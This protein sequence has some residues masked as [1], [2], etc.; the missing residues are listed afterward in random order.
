M[1]G[2]GDGAAVGVLREGVG[3]ATE[4]ADNQGGRAT[5]AIDIVAE[6]MASGALRKEGTTYK[7]FD[8]T[9]MNPKEG[10]GTS[11]HHFEA[12]AIGVVKGE[13]DTGGIFAWWEVSGVSKP[14]GWEKNLSAVTDGVARELLSE[15]I[16]SGD[17]AIRAAADG[18]AAENDVAETGD[19]D[20]A[21][22]RTEGG[23]E[24]VVE[25]RDVFGGWGTFK[26][27]DEIFA[28]GVG[29][30][31]MSGEELEGGV[32]GVKLVASVADE[33]AGVHGVE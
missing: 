7:R 2:G 10:R 3:P 25:D 4:G 17:G 29:G 11:L 27:E 23:A 16:G 19:R 5:A 24:N 1:F 6:S 30:G 21:G 12:G 8:G 31:P 33:L 32:N 20:A 9:H 14:S 22:T 26:C 28:E 13:D 15:V 18:H